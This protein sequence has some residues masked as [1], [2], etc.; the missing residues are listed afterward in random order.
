M[1]HA[2][3]LFPGIRKCLPACFFLLICLFTV[4]NARVQAQT[5]ADAALQRGASWLQAQVQSNGHLASEP[6]SAALPLQ[7]RSEAAR[8]LKALSIQP[9]PSTLFSA[10]DSLSAD[11]TEYLARRAMARQL[12]GTADAAVLDALIALQN[13]DGSFGAA[14]GYPGNPQDTA[15]AL[16]ALAAS[17]ASSAAASEALGWLAATQQVDGAWPLMPDGDAVVTSA[18]AVQALTLYRQQ[19]AVRAVLTKARTW[20]MDQRTAQHAWGDDLR[21]A[22]ALLAVL[23]GLDNATSVRPALDT[24]RQSQRADGSWASE[25]HLTALALRALWLA[26]QPATNPDLASVTGQLVNEA[27]QPLVGVTVQLAPAGAQAITDAQGRFSFTQLAEGSARV[28]IQATGFLGLVTDIQLSKGQALDLGT[29]VLRAISGGNASTVTITGVAQYSDDGV[30]WRNAANA[31]IT[32]GALSTTTNA[33]GEYTLANVPPGA[34]SLRATYSSYQPVTASFT[35]QAGQQVRFDPKFVRGA[36]GSTL[37]VVVASEQAGA[38]IAGA[39]VVLNGI[40]R[41]ANAN[42]EAYFATGVNAGENTVTASASG[43]GTR[44]IT[45]NV[46]GR[47]N[48]IL[49]ITLAA[50]SALPPNQTV[51][52]GVVTDAD[53]ALPLS[54]ATV[55]VQST[56]LQALTD[57]R[58]RYAVSASSGLAGSR[59]ILIEKPGYQSHAQT[60][61]LTAGAKHQFDVPLKAVARPGQPIELL[62]RVSNEATRQPI[63]GAQITLSGSN[64]HKVQTSASGEAQVTGVNAGTTQFRVTA[65]GY[66]AVAFSVDLQAG[67]RYEIPIELKPAVV[68]SQRVYGTV[69]DAQSRRPVAGA[70]VVFSGSDSRETV[71]DSQGRYEFASITAGRWNLSA[72][73]TGYR[74][75]SRGFDLQGSTQFDLLLTPERGN[76]GVDQTLRTIAVGHP[77]NSGG[78]V[79]YLFIFGTPGTSGLVVSND[80]RVNHDFSIDASGVAEIMVPSSQFLSPSGAVLDKAMLVYASKP[81]SASFLNRQQFT[82][83]M[84][85]LL[86]VPALGTSHRVMTWGNGIGYVQMSLTAVADGTVATIT[87]AK[88]FTSGQAAGKAFDITLNKGQSVYYTAGSGSDLTGTLVQS[89]KP[90]AVFGGFQCSNVPSGVAYCDH[91]FSQIPPIQHWA[92]EYIVPET[93]RTDS[94]GNLV[95]ILAHADGTQLTINGA[96]PIILNAGQIHEIET[97]RDLHISAS[98][99]ILVGQYLKGRTAAGTGD[100]A[101]SFIAGIRQTLRDY[102]FTA[103]VNLAKYDENFLNIAIP[104]KALG[105]LKLN[106][107]SVAAADF[108]VVAGTVYS[109]GRIAIAAGPGRISADEAFLATISGFSTDD[110]YH[111]IIGVDYSTGASSTD[112]VVTSIV[113]ATDQPSYPAQTAARLQATVTNQGRNDANL[114]VVLR[115]NDAQGSEVVR[116]ARR[117]LGNVAPGASAQHEEPWN[118]ATYPAGSYTLIAD[119]LNVRGEIVGTASTLFAII[120]GSGAAGAPKGAL[121]VATDKAEYQ[122]DDRVRLN[123]LA[124]NLTANTLIDEARVMIHVQDPAGRQVFTHVHTLG[125]LNTTAIRASDVTQMLRNAPGGTYTVKARLLGNGNNLKRQASRSLFWPPFSK[126][127]DVDV[128]LA[129]A[130][131]TFRVNGPAGA[132][133][134]ITAVPATSPGGLALLAVMLALAAG[135]ARKRNHRRAD[136][137]TGQRSSQEDAQ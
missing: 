108:R 101:F 68:G 33:N 17:R 30:A 46:Q 123:T 54:G 61:A 72:T 7:A 97:A 104:T 86:D 26:A 109:T 94:V 84:S 93:A 1:H 52:E 21:T 14:A 36:T 115:I 67:Q 4:F 35:A 90:L 13:T 42:G 107:A 87:P 19:P 137:A 111:T 77:N 64:P 126:A 128:E 85:Y 18:L 66:D 76:Q 73:A 75:T 102:V 116:F 22:Q 25:P 95:R 28:S 6:A 100:P 117:A 130:T 135:A 29:I 34:A 113:A 57:A 70:K 125:Q 99:P 43:H 103:P 118:T 3:S 88:S 40:Q 134:G 74:G 62:L 114:Q 69:L 16:H 39:N 41:Q 122:P 82:T 24:L 80:R 9:L 79:G 23:P 65:L 96:V 55:R 51:L 58:G 124:R 15:W 112:P 12:A 105:S 31:V 50:A 44:I 92:S 110:S 11:T 119:L 129:S 132:G 48:V 59:E 38:P 83:D 133:D 60:I 71:A 106:G 47:Q 131:T 98:Q 81:I 32:V 8:T 37:K 121:S 127:Y 63:Q 2:T 45:F 10:I 56:G 49:P 78:A 5:P 91:L 27:R 120:S 20:L 136:V 53:T 89:S